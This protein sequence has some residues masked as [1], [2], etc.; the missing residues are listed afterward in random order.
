MNSSYRIMVAGLVLPCRR[1]KGVSSLLVLLMAASY[2]FGSSSM[3]HSVIDDNKEGRATVARAK[4][5]ITVDGLL[6]EQDWI[7]ASPAGE[8]LQREPRPGEKASERTELKLLYDDSNLYVGVTCYDSEPNRIIGTQMERDADLSA[9]D[10]IEL[11][12][13]S[14]HD[15]HNAY[16]FSTNPLGALVDGLIIENGR[17]N[18]NWNAI[19]YVRTHRSDAGWTA[20]FAIPFKSIGFKSGEAVWGFNFSR[21]IKRKLEEDRWASPRLDLKFFQVS[22]AGEIT[23]L[24]GIHQG[25]GL[26]VRPFISTR[27]LH[28]VETGNDVSAK[29]GLDIFYNITPS[30]KWTT[31]INT[32]FGETE[33]DSRQIN[34]TRFELFFPEKRSFFL[35]NA[36]LF[37]VG[38]DSDDEADVIPFFS[39]RIGLLE[40]GQEVPILAGTKLTGKQGPYTVGVIAVRTRETDFA[41]ARNFFVARVKRDFFKQSYIGGIYT[42]GN[43]E[44]STSSRTFGGDIR[45]FTSKFLGRERNFGVDGFYLKTANEAVSGRDSSYGFGVSCPNDLWSASASWKRIGENFHPALGFVPRSSVDKLSL[46]FEFDPRP[47]D[48]LNV[49]QMFHELFFSHFR[50]I[51]KGRT[52]SWRLFSAPVNY[53]LN[54]GE[55]IEFNYAPQFE[56]LFEPFEIAKGVVLS[57][58]DYRFT[59]WRFEINTAS[60]RPWKFDNAWWF[61]SYWSGHAH[62]FSTSFEYKVAPHF[63]MS[64]GWDQT[65]ARLKEGNFVARVFTIRANYSVNPYLT[66][67]NL[68]QFDSESKN[69]GWQSR[70][71]WILRPGN[72]LFLVFN[73]G[74][75]QD[76]RGGFGFR[77]VETKLSGKFQYTF[78]F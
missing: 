63:L 17:L 27:G 4:S 70:V 37:S 68:I 10:R 18:R 29:A 49:R 39:R 74:W 14:F 66:L 43:P 78:R 38:P 46:G 51:D 12:I 77:A 55:H 73:Q 60:K 59:R 5:R 25:R 7:E 6:N 21:T 2:G 32:D 33:V 3:R 16:Y 64:A 45:L 71:R 69:L 50:R 67:F 13:D 72:E 41:E 26:D 40:S 9:D 62:Q 53:E 8:I 42:A 57:P 35:E 58:G 28:N 61:G 47:K 22:E 36:G 56:R 75:L 54:S 11:L 34:L 76:P 23:G 52:E 1:V 19:W 31:T 48:F 44:Q 65:F 20:E 24:S 30:L 15:R